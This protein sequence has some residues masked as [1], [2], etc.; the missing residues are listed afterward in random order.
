VSNAYQAILRSAGLEHVTL[1]AKTTTLVLDAVV[2][3]RLSTDHAFVCLECRY[4]DLARFVYV[5]DVES[6]IPCV[7]GQLLEE[8][9]S[10]SSS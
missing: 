5:I 2:T 4:P 1:D 6:L 3:V 8:T 10:A 9:S 7:V